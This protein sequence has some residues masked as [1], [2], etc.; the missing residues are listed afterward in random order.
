MSGMTD[1]TT[2]A[3]TNGVAYQSSGDAMPLLPQR[4]IE[5]VPVREYMALRA[6]R[7]GRG[8]SIA[9]GFVFF[10][11]AGFAWI[12]LLMARGN[13]MGGGFCQGDVEMFYPW[14]WWYGF[15]DWM[16]QIKTGAVTTFA[17]IFGDGAILALLGCGVISLAIGFTNIRRAAFIN[18]II[19]SVVTATATVAAFIG[20]IYAYPTSPYHYYPI[21]WTTVLLYLSVLAVPVVLIAMAKTCSEKLLQFLKVVMIVAVVLSL[22]GIPD[23]TD[24]PPH[25]F[26]FDFEDVLTVVLINF[27]DLVLFAAVMAMAFGLPR[28]ST[29]K[30]L[31]PRNNVLFVTSTVA[32]AEG[33]V[34]FFVLFSAEYVSS[35]ILG[36]VLFCAAAYMVA[37]GVL[38]VVYADNRA[39]FSL[40]VGLGIGLI[41][42][43]AI[44]LFIE[45]WGS[46]AQL[47]TVFT[48]IAIVYVVGAVSLR[49]PKHAMPSPGG[50]LCHPDPMVYDNSQSSA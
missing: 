31:T 4:D 25:P 41:A 49:Q 3:S 28:P 22:I 35:P 10:F 23:L 8:A 34:V 36:S 38:G 48:T 7:I 46:Y 27:S 32:V 24:N 13:P 5:P 43:Q 47:L 30:T 39:K 9:A 44:W 15:N 6:F 40:L 18:G 14:S 50:P 26:S 19:L 12:N 2:D 1:F 29:Q 11:A 20:M 33:A 45:D 37:A 42:V 16:C 21:S 17:N